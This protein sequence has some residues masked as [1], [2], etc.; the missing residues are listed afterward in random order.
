MAEHGRYRAQ[1]LA[2]AHTVAVLT[3]WPAPGLLLL[4]LPLPR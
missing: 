4:P 2:G 3:S 1:Q